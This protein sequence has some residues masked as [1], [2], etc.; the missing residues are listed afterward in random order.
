M[1]FDSFTLRRVSPMFTW[2][3]ATSTCFLQL[4]VSGT[5]PS[6]RRPTSPGVMGPVTQGKR[7]ATHTN[8]HRTGHTRKRAPPLQASSGIGGCSSRRGTQSTPMPWKTSCTTRSPRPY[9][10]TANT[11]FTQIPYRCVRGT[12]EIQ[13]IR[14]QNVSAGSNVR[15]VRQTSRDF[16]HRCRRTRRRKAAQGF[17]SIS[18]KRACSRQ[19]MTVRR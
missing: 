1:P 4:N 5:A 10:S 9:R 17:S 18:C 11:S 13:M 15:A 12:A 16:L 19:S 8:C 14:L 2:S 6:R 3:R 7:S